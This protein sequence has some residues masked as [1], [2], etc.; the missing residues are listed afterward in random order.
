MAGSQRVAIRVK[1][2]AARTSVGGCY[3]GPRGSALVVA[4]TARAVDG[5]ATQA[6][7]RAVAAALGVRPAA[8]R[9]VSGATSRDKVVEV[10]PAPVDLGDRVAALRDSSA[11][12]RD[13]E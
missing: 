8:V 1:P 13:E 11:E 4:V 5:R 6:A 3:A 9:L 10:D 12:I 2:G 7:V